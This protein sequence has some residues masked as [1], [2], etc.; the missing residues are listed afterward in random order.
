[1]GEVDADQLREVNAHIVALAASFGR[2][3]GTRV[4]AW[5]IRVGVNPR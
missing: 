3:I 5:G 1:M 4:R 2:L